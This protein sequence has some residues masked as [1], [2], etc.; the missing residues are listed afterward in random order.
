MS[1]QKPQNGGFP[2]SEDIGA[3]IRHARLIML[4]FD[5]PTLGF[6]WHPHNE[7]HHLLMII[8]GLRGLAGSLELP[9]EFIPPSELFNVGRGAGGSEIAS[10]GFRSRMVKE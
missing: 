5:D 9:M 1:A 3:I 4:G 8:T 6:F 10:V 2:G 7:T